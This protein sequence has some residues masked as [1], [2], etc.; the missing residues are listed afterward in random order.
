MEFSSPWKVR[1]LMG[2]GLRNRGKINI[3][4]N[5]SEFVET[6]TP[7]AGNSFDTLNVHEPYSQGYGLVGSENRYSSPPS[8]YFVPDEQT[9]PVE[10]RDFAGPPDSS[11]GLP[12]GDIPRDAAV[13][14]VEDRDLSSLAEVEK[15]IAKINGSAGAEDRS[16]EDLI[17][18]D[19]A[20][21]GD[22]AESVPNQHSEPAL[23][24]I[25]D[26]Y[27]PYEDISLLYQPQVDVDIPGP[28]VVDT[29]F[30]ADGSGDYI[31]AI[32]SL[33]PDLESIIG[34]FHSSD[35]DLD[36]TLLE[37]LQ[38]DEMGAIVNPFDPYLPEVP[39]ENDADLEEDELDPYSEVF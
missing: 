1:E 9:I 8:H 2:F 29:P 26:R 10:S 5:G 23:P 17:R 33:D 35:T 19:E 21:I 36:D 13:R 3:T 22:M 25:S 6:R 28:D 11:D 37:I 34:D 4:S 30:T 14:I 24:E 32:E 39:P 18:E 31:G 16:R 15:A 27:S 38:E 20:K 12:V 7:D